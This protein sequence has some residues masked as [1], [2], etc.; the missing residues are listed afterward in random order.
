LI[1]VMRRDNLAEASGNGKRGQR[2]VS[3]NLHK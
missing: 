3:K 1:G 2:G